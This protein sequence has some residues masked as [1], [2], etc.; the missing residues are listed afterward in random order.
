[1]VK[2]QKELLFDIEALHNFCVE[3][4]LQPF[5][6]KQ[7]LYEVFKNQNIF[8]DD[9]T[10]LS[11]DLKKDLDASF[12]VLSL[13]VDQTKEDIE[14]TKFSFLTKDDAVV[15]TV[16][17]YH[18]KKINIWSDALNKQKIDY[19]KLNRITICISCQVGCPVWCE[20]CV[21]GELWLMR[22]LSCGEIM[23]QIFYANW[24]IK[25]KFWKKEDGTLNKIRNVVFM[26]MWE[27]L[28]NYENV[29]KTFWYLLDQNKLS[30]SR[31][32]ITISTCGI[33]PG[34]QRLIDDKIEIK[35]AVSLHAPNQK[36]REE[37]IPIAKAY[38]LD[39][40]MKVLDNYVIATNN[41]IFY[42]YIMIDGVTDKLD[43]AS[44]MVVLLRGKLCH[45]NLIPYNENPAIDFWESSAR[46]MVKFKNILEKG[47]LTVT[48][49]DSMWRQ[50]KSACGQLWYDKV[51]KQ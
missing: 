19:T 51:K 47:G 14:T 23:S 28:L 12:D 3:K 11:K 4:R 50:V 33:V 21:T 43:L 8:F 36:L 40:L 1:M 49:R 9:M 38:P 7:I 29:K 45:I 10:T 17:M 26:G 31:R 13:S 41:R 44:E 46:Q 27:P 34:I 15:E 16:L 30:L 2:K 25:H 5:R 42:E 18:Y 20:F 39:K 24:Y 48:I 22:N 32:H 35:L 6:E 37:L